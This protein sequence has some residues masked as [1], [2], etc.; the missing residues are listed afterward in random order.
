MA[1]VNKIKDYIFASVRLRHIVNASALLAYVNEELTKKAIEEEFGGELIFTGGGITQATFQDECQANEC[2][3]KLKTLYPKETIA[4]TVEV[5][6]ECCASEEHFVDAV[7]GARRKVREAKEAG[8]SEQ[9]RPFDSIPFS[10]G[11]PFFRICAQTGKAFATR[12][13]GLGPEDEKQAF[14]ENAWKQNQTPPKHGDIDHKQGD[15]LEADPEL[16]KRL[17]DAINTRHADK[18]KASEIKINADTFKYSA[19][20]EKL[21]IPSKPQNYL[22]FM[23]ADGNGMGEMLSQLSRECATEKDYRAF[24]KILKH[25]TRDAYLEAAVK[26]LVPFLEEQIDRGQ[27]ENDGSLLLPRRGIDPVVHARALRFLIRQGRG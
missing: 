18:L 9:E 21:S 4:A 17:S 7:E 8:G 23:D 10:G 6:V 16:R 2:A 5:G 24:S 19:D 26:V 25:S 15:R 14:G 27:F 12:W 20:L 3:Q 11:A 1:D 22:G 13:G